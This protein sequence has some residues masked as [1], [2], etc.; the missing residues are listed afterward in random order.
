MIDGRDEGGNAVMTERRR[1]AIAGK[2]AARV[3]AMMLGWTAL[4]LAAPAA[5]AQSQQQIDRCVNKEGKYTTDVQI[6]SCTAVIESRAAPNNRVLAY[7]F[8]AAGYAANKDYDRAIAD[9]TMAIN[10]QIATGVTAGID[11]VYYFRGRAYSA[12]SDYDRALA[13]FDEAIKRAP[14]PDA[15]YY[16][17]R[18]GAYGSKGEWAKAI[19][20][21]D[22]AIR[23]DPNNAR[24]YY[25]RGLAKRITGDTAGGD[26]DVARAHQLDP[27]LGND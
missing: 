5:V 7:F 12:K 15:D 1:H 6:K 2:L 13:D 9:Y 8:R 21:L 10:I 16:F 22:E 19:A 25:F 23:L 17:F 18:G 4:L 27:K 24:A 3:A 11:I 20:D 26:A 14:K